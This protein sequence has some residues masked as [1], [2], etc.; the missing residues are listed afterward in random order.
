MKAKAKTSGYLLVASA[1]RF[2]EYMQAPNARIQEG[3][4]GGEWLCE[5]LQLNF[6]GN[7]PSDET[8]GYQYIPVALAKHLILKRTSATISRPGCFTALPKASR[9]YPQ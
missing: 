4:T 3:T 1:N 9:S 6:L 5:H 7:D 8:P 2:S